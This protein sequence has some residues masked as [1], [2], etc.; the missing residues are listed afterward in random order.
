MGRSCCWPPPSAEPAQLQDPWVRRR[1][2]FGCTRVALFP[3][4]DARPLLVVRVLAVVAALV[5]GWSVG[6]AVPPLQLLAV[7]FT[8]LVGGLAALTVARSRMP[9]LT[10][11]GLAITVGVAGC[12]AAVAYVAAIEPAGA[13]GCLDDLSVVLALL[14][15]G[16]LWVALTPPRGLVAARTTRWLGVGAGIVSASTGACHSDYDFSRRSPVRLSAALVMCCLFA[17]RCAHRPA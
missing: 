9:R 7:T 6:W 13:R 11:A 15:T 16:Y 8:G 10:A 17:G 4:R 12:V 3:P 5:S 1:F 14:L 2:A